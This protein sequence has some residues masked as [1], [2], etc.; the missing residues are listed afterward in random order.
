VA[1]FKYISIIHSQSS[2][3]LSCCRSAI[4]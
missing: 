4:L 2:S 1:Y 3:N